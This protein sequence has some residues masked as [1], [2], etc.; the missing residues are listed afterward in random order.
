MLLLDQVLNKK[1]GKPF[2]KMPSDEALPMLAPAEVVIINFLII[3][4]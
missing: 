1:L 4:L 2:I 3:F